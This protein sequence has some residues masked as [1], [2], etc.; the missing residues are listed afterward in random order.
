M[1]KDNDLYKYYLCYLTDKQSYSNLSD[2]SIELLKISESAFT[3]FKYYYENNQNFREKID[4]IYK[5]LLR[6]KQIDNIFNKKNPTDETHN[7]I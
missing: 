7:E 3:D 6:D 4:K 5:Y 2:G 1:I